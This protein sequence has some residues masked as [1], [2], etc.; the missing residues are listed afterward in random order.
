MSKNKNSKN[1]NNN[2]IEV[3]EN[4][5]DFVNQEMKKEELKAK[6]DKKVNAKSTKADKNSQKGKN[7]KKKANATEKRTIGQGA[8]ATVS[9]L[10]KVTWPTFGQTLKQTGVVIG[11]VLIFVVLL[12]GLN[13]LFGWL[14]NLIVGAL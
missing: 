12:L 1:L 5:S 3:K 14:F 9:E 13:S 2:A 11:F 6:E 10:K 8:R 4:D 7:N